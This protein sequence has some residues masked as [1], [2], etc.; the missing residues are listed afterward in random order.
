MKKRKAK[1]EK[2]F[3]VERKFLYGQEHEDRKN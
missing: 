1:R 2:K 3:H